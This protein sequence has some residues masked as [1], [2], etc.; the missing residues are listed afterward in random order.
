VRPCVFEEVVGCSWEIMG[1][2][3]PAPELLVGKRT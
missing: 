2:H 3:R 1:R